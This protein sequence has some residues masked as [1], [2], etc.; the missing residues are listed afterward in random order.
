MEVPVPIERL[1][2]IAARAGVCVDWYPS[3]PCPRGCYVR[4]D[5]Q[6]L[7]LLSPALRDSPMRLRCALAHE[8]GH[9]FVGTGGPLSLIKDEAGADRWARQL[10]LPEDWVIDHRHL[11]PGEMAEEAGVY[12]MWVEE[13]LREIQQHISGG[14]HV[15]LAGAS[16]HC[17]SCPWR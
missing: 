7:I 2:T 15:C 16:Q 4:V 11:S 10:L 6:A 9:H 5:G 17:S 1:F 3:T 13:R 8:L 12:Q 14:H